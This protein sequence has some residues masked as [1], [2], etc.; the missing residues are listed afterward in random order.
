M[1]TPNTIAAK[2]KLQKKA[3]QMA[4][5]VAA[6]IAIHSC[7]HANRCNRVPLSRKRRDVMSIFTE[8]GP[9]YT[10]R[11]YRMSAEA[12]FKPHDI[13]FPQLVRP[14]KTRG[15]P[16]GKINSTI[17]LAVALRFFAGGSPYDLAI[18]HGIS[19]SSVYESVWTVVDTINQCSALS[20]SFPS[21][22]AE[23]L[24][25]AKEF[26]KKSSAGFDCCVGAIDGILIWTEKPT[27]QDC[28]LAN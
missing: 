15:T 3:N 18:V 4:A 27:P 25:I 10:Q 2:K 11:A 26:G 12:F 1:T 23:Q 5:I 8:L 9:T 24:H 17:N 13:L 6:A 14:R 20:F 19:H 22:H 21:C 7:Q 28:S 16:N